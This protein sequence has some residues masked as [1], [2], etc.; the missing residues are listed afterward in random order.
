MPPTP[1][2]ALAVAAQA[3]IHRIALPTPFAIGP[4]NTYLIED[5]PL[6]LVDVGPNTGSALGVLEAG[7]ANLGHRL[8]DLGLV[9]VTHQHIDHLGLAGEITR[10]TGVPVAC[11]DL[12]APYVE[13]FERAAAQDDDDARLLMLRHGV[14]VHVADAL[15]EVATVVHGFGSSAP[16][17][18]TLQDG[19]TL[20]LRDRTF[21]VLHR[22]GHSPSDTVLVDEASGIA[23]AGDHLLSG[24]SSNALISRPLK[25]FDGTRPQPLVQYRASLRATRE[26]DLRI[27]LGGH[28]EP[29][30][31]HRSLIDERLAA[32]ER[33]AAKFLG[34]LED[35]PLSAHE[36][37]DATWGT[38]AF[39]QAFLTLS[40]V[41]GHL[42]LLVAEGQV[43]EDRSETV[44]RFHRV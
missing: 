36:I 25:D 41:L 7:L 6:T 14:D 2:D 35:G 21:T 24:I 15:R 44:V 39:T 26:L 11:L 23:L 5:D 10:R 30:T 42:D 37:A 16:V 34:L 22:P 33:R 27:A 1:T 18:R 28:R 19:G 4:V 20:A 38:V 43:V 8:E 9:V 40:E 32:H 17:H 12:L 13:N 3:G 31:D 29:V